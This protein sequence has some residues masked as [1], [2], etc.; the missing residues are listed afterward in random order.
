MSGP[1]GWFRRRRV[2]AAAGLKRGA[3]R[4]CGWARGWDGGRHRLRP[5]LILLEDRCLLSGTFTVT[6]T[7]DSAPASNPTSG[8]LRWAVEQANAVSGG[9][10]INF[11]LSAPATIILAQGQLELSNQTG[12]IAIDGP[13]AGLTISGN[14]LNRVFQVDK[15]ATATISSLTISDGLALTVTGEPNS[16]HGGGLLNLGTVTLSNSTIS[17]NTATGDP[18]SA[19]LGG[20]LY[21]SGQAT[22]TDCTIS[23]NSDGGVFNTGTVTLT[24]STVVYNTFSAGLENQSGTADLTACTVS[25][26][27]FFGLTNYSSGSP[28]GTIALTDTIVE[29]NLNSSSQSSDIGGSISNLVTGSYN[30]IGRGGSGGIANGVDGNIVLG[31]N[32][33][34]DPY[35]ASLG[36]YGGPTQ[37]M[38]LRPGSLAIGAGVAVSGITT[39]QRGFPLDSPVDIGAFQA[40]AGPLVVDSTADGINLLPGQ[41]DFA[42]CRQPGQRPDRVPH[43]HLRP[44]RLLDAP[45]DRFDVRRGQLRPVRVDRHRRTGG[46][47]ADCQRRW[48]EPSLR[49]AER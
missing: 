10:T 24:E 35:L 11:N 12:T 13:S 2:S 45:D 32:W 14:D 23:G 31:S 37:T 8:T 9:A 33:L 17:G 18:A 5:A 25:G 40:Q 36:D 47:A 41:L 6:S 20:G 15:G 39:D 27:T 21:N 30:L 3:G 29:D 44:G 46:R 48:A 26:N 16:G 7:A 38:A 49:L 42:R 43:D 28:V 22:L 34:D 1:T 4:G 19:T